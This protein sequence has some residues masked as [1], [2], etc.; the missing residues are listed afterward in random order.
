M[1]C[2]LLPLSITLMS[3]LKQKTLALTQE[4]SVAISGKSPGRRYRSLSPDSQKRADRMALA[5]RSAQKHHK[6]SWVEQKENGRISDHGREVSEDEDDPTLEERVELV[7]EDDGGTKD[8]GDTAQEEDSE[9]EQAQLPSSFARM[10]ATPRIVLSS[11]EEDEV[12]LIPLER[13]R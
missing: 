6:P 5:Q 13:L 7:S 4:G 9:T 2:E 10:K 8:D 12:R 1:C 11:D 3:P